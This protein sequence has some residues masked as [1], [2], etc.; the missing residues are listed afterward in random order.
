YDDRSH[1]VRFH[2][3]QHDTL[4]PDPK[5]IV[6]IQEVLSEPPCPGPEVPMDARAGESVPLENAIQAA[7]E[8]LESPSAGTI[9]TIGPHWPSVAWERDLLGKLDH[10]FFPHV[11]DT[12]SEGDRTYLVE[13]RPAGCPFWDAWDDPKSSD[14]DR[15]GWLKQIGEALDRLHQHGA[16]LEGLWP[17]ILVLNPEGQVRITDLS[18]LLPLPLPEHS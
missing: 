4:T 11:L 14:R 10:A 17:E 16:I 12:F 5:P 6:L 1:V 9:M 18:G 8:E 13:E 7:V 15:F 2:G 3:R